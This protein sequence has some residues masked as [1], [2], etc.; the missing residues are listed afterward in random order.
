MNP[1]FEAAL[2]AR[3]HWMSVVS[4]KGITGFD[5]LAQES[6]EAASCVVSDLAEYEANHFGR[7]GATV[8]PLFAEIPELAALY[9]R[10]FQST[11][12]KVESERLK[13]ARQQKAIACIKANAWHEILL[14]TP[15]ELASDLQSGTDVSIEGH[16]LSYDEDDRVVWVDNPYGVLGSLGEEPTV[17]LARTFLA[18]VAMGG[19]FGPEL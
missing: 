12:R 16:Y 18:C 17:G 2:D 1:S 10:V 14:P 6:E 7:Y 13:L 3:L 19:M 8:P 4:F 9:S 5:A 15:E 11:A